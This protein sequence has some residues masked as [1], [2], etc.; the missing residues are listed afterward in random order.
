MSHPIW[1]PV[2]W[3]SPRP[4]ACTL[5]CAV[6]S[7]QHWGNTWSRI[8]MNL[9]NFVYCPLNSSWLPSPASTCLILQWSWDPCIN[10]FLSLYR[11]HNASLWMFHRV[12]KASVWA[13]RMTIRRAVHIR[14]C[15]AGTWEILV[16]LWLG[17]THGIQNKESEGNLSQPVADIKH[18]KNSWGALMKVPCVQRSFQSIDSLVTMQCGA[19]Y[20]SKTCWLQM[21]QKSLDSTGY[22]Q[23]S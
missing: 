9:F 20:F 17:K 7:G 4:H 19:G 10:R 8:F 2:L 22:C 3:N 14:V 5:S 23:C 6:S 12:R 15:M 16:I 11:W 18:Y 21:P 1:F 13:K